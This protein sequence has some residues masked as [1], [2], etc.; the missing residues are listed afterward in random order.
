[1]L[2]ALSTVLSAF[3]EEMYENGVTETAGET[4]AGQNGARN[5]ESTLKRVSAK[6]GVNR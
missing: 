6:V 2:C 4:G 3:V 1:M 5:I